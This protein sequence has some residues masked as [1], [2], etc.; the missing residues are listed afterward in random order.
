MAHPCEDVLMRHKTVALIGSCRFASEQVETGCEHDIVLHTPRLGGLTLAALCVLSMLVATP[1]HAFVLR[2]FSNQTVTATVNGHSYTMVPHSSVTCDYRNDSCTG[3]AD[4]AAAQTNQVTLQ[5]EAETFAC[6]LPL[7]G[8]GT[9]IF[10]ELSRAPLNVPY[11]FV[12]SSFGWNYEVIAEVP[13]GVHAT[14]RNVRFLATADP[15]YDATDKFSCTFEE[16]SKGC[17]PGDLIDANA[18]LGTMVSL[19]SHDP[20]IRGAVIAGDL[21]QNGQ[22]REFDTY[23]DQL[24][25]LS[26]FFYDGF[27][28]HDPRSRDLWL[29]DFTTD[30]KCRDPLYILND[31]G[32]RKHATRLTNS[33]GSLTAQAVGVNTAK[34]FHYSWDWHDVH[35]V[36]LNMFPGDTKGGYEAH[37]PL[38]SLS[39]LRNDLAAAVGSSGRP[40]VLI[41]HFGF[42]CFSF[43]ALQST[44]AAAKCYVKTGGSNPGDEW[45]TDAQRTDYWNLLSDYNVAAIITGHYHLSTEHKINEWAL[46]FE[47]PVNA[48]ARK[49]GRT[50]LP[51]FIAGAARG[52][53]DEKPPYTHYA[54]VF[55]DFSM[56][57]CSIMVTRKAPGG[58]ELPD[59]KLVYAA[60]TDSSG[61]RCTRLE[62]NDDSPALTYRGGW[63]HLTGRPTGFHDTHDDVHATTGFGDS[64]SLS[65]YGTQVSYIAEISDGYGEVIVELDDMAAQ[66]VNLDEKGVRNQGGTVKYTS[67]ELPLG[68]HT[69]TLTKKTGVYMLVDGFSIKP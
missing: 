50:V 61:A 44:N 36:Q 17:D 39:F 42:D 22:K 63:S 56:D 18:T 34:N 20:T 2:N 60:P 62:L 4:D 38:L 24:G 41:H 49:D 8:G 15:Q 7:V 40:V 10:Q 23:K 13:Y 1:S 48:V 5:M 68:V 65:F 6:V 57:E 46:P 33:G 12:C 58:Q 59:Q 3:I 43:G 55:L 54:G 47:K 66:I 21:V 31:I 11:Q 53:T 14:Q 37:D 30:T 28:N 26:R 51:T 52:V 9:A 64:V 32:S 16:K 29:C 19:I 25:G 35:F 45:W 27:G 67:Q 69:L